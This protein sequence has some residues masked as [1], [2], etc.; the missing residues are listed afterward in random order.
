MLTTMPTSTAHAL[1]DDMVEY[2]GRPDT[3][4][5]DPELFGFGSLY[6]LY[7]ASDDWIFLAAPA[8]R[9]WPALIRALRNE[10]DFEADPRF[11]D[12]ESRRANAS[13]LAEVLS[14]TFSTK[15]ARYW[16][17]HLLSYDV[18]C[19]VA[20]K[21]PPEAILQSKEFAVASDLLVEVEHPTFGEHVRLK[22]YVQMSR[23]STVAEA[24]CLVGQHTDR[25]L[26][27]LGYSAD[28]IC[29]L[30]ERKVVA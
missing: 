5:A 25:I 23:S 19:L 3:L 8:E 9:E 10:V 26:R 14:A 15:P 24:G 20:H 18:G 21:E 1:A 13:A 2:A 27:E 16:E 17:D 22:P 30:R 12:A 6:R 4:T 29:D 28:A 7:R 11:S